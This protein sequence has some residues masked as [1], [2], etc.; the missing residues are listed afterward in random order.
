MSRLIWVGLIVAA[1]AGGGLFLA[2]FETNVHR[3][4]NGELQS[5]TITPRGGPEDTVESRSTSAGPSRPTI[6]IATF[7]LVRL[8]ETKLANRQVSDVLVRLLSKFDVVAV[9]DVQAR[10]RG[11]LLRLV[12]QINA[13][14]RRYQFAAERNALDQS[15]AFVFDQDT[16]EVDP[17]TVGPVED[18]DGRFRHRPLVALFRVHGP[19]P[20]E[21]FT[22]KLVNIHI[23][24]KQAAA[25]LGLLDDVYRAV[26]DDGAN[27]D[28]V[29]LLGD[30][31][32]DTDRMDQF[33]EILDV[34][35]S[36]TGTPTTVQG[37]GP[38]DNILFDRR[39]T[40]EFTGRAE[41]VDLMREFDLTLQAALEVSDHLPVW[42]EFGS[43]EGYE[44]AHM[45]EKAA[46]TT[47]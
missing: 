17:S 29:I 42:A 24:P 12:E 30:F 28:D 45:A 9:Q 8:D 5:I 15:S 14:G 3:G 47:R 31:G 13:T 37:I 41:V 19:D 40:T 22:F 43:C 1:V 34:T 6:R 11:V 21:A 39:A 32:A 44:S 33:A 25:E 35:T 27:E 36:I 4:E 10:N 38:V 2:N 16:I 18:P 7:N 20:A 26:R 46:R 23:D